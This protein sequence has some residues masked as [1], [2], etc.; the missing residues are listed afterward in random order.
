M[1]QQTA[2]EL[3]N[4]CLLDTERLRG[5]RVGIVGAGG[6][7]C[8]V[9]VHLAGAGVGTLTLFDFDTVSESNL[10]RQ[11]L[12]EPSDIGEQKAA[13]AAQRLSRFAPECSIT[14]LCR[15]IDSSNAAELTDG[16]D[17]VI[18]A[19]DNLK[20]R[21]A[22]NFARVHAA[23]PLM[24][25]GISRG[26]GSAYL[27]TPGVACLGCVL[28]ALRESADKRTVSAAA[29][30]VGSFAAM[31]ALAYLSGKSGLKPGELLLIDAV[32]ATAEKLPVKK[33]HECKICGGE[34]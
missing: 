32:G 20:T 9:A 28:D 12:Y 21:L 16:F 4:G 1:S 33:S 10:N 18:L 27:Y 29:G 15:K 2:K 34:K 6:L 31:A 19:C 7:G 23:K 17:L 11:F 24:D 14:A 13:L 22:V 8:N 3:Q 25:C 30:A 5:V 26:C